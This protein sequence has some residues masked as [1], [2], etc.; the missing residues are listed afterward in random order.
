MIT[1]CREFRFFWEEWAP[2]RCWALIFR[3]GAY[4]NKYGNRDLFESCVR[5]P[6]S[7]VVKRRQW[8]WLGHVLRIEAKAGSAYKCTGTHTTREMKERKTTKIACEM[9]E[10][11]K[12]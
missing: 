6:P 7:T 1:S 5:E 12:L 11:R 9:H 3:V 4:S 8:S 10:E 2:V